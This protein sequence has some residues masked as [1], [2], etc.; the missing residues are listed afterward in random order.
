MDALFPLL[1]IP[2]LVWDAESWHFCRMQGIFLDSLRERRIEDVWMHEA[3][4]LPL[5]LGEKR[6]L[7]EV[8]DAL[9]LVEGMRPVTVETVNQELEV[10]L[11]DSTGEHE[12]A[13]IG[14]DCALKVGSAM[15]QLHP[16]VILGKVHVQ[17]GFIEGLGKD[18]RGGAV[19]VVG[20]VLGEDELDALAA[21][22]E[23]FYELLPQPVGFG[24]RTLRERAG[25]KGIG[26]SLLVSGIQTF[27]E[28]SRWCMSIRRCMVSAGRMPLF[29]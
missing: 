12:V 22:R 17:A 29:S 1:G 5:L 20:R 23:V 25:G 26:G 24:L 14:A 28:A 11:C 3:G 16:M 4:G 21:L 18:I 19:H 2:V 15:R 6:G 9:Q 27:P 10:I 13:V 8:Q 7:A